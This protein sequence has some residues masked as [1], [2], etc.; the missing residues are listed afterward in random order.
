MHCVITDIDVVSLHACNNNLPTCSKCIRV[1]DDHHHRFPLRM[2]VCHCFSLYRS[3]SPVE[4]VVHDYLC[5]WYVQLLHTCAQMPTPWHTRTRTILG[6]CRRSRGRG[7]EFGLVA[8]YVFLF[9]ELFRFQRLERGLHA[10]TVGVR[11]RAV[12]RI[13]CII[14]S[15]TCLRMKASVLVVHHE[16]RGM[17]LHAI[18]AIADDHLLSLSLS[19]FPAC[20]CTHTQPWGSLQL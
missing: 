20:T 5:E 14:M 2:P 19:L 10:L 18:V 9:L 1:S 3:R 15:D 13:V 17:R 8:L 16:M 7:L 6:C 4:M 12:V 11:R